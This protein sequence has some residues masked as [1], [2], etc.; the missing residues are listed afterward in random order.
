VEGSWQ[1]V[2]PADTLDLVRLR[3]LATILSL[4]LAAALVTEAHPA[5]ARST[6]AAEVALHSPL[7]LGG[8]VSLPEAGRS[9]SAV[10]AAKRAQRIP[11]RIA[12]LAGPVL[13]HP[14]PPA[15]TSAASRPLFHLK[16]PT[17]RSAS[18]DA[19]ESH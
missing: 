9:T 5:S 14:R 6:T 15:A 10:S 2:G 16:R 1:P 13:L 18:R 8:F 3:T 17:P 12:R 19:D 4:V 11:A 7:G